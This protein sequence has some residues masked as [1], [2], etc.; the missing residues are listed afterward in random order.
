MRDILVVCPQERDLQAI[1]AAG[2]DARY[3]IH[4]VGGDLDAIDLFDPAAFVEETTRFRRTAS[5]APRIAQRCSP[6]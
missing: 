4:F 2:L 3:R 1:R 5:S 6:R